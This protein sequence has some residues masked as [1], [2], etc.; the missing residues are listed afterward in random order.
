MQRVYHVS[1]KYFL[2]ILTVSGLLIQTAFY[3]IWTNKN[4][5]FISVNELIYQDFDSQVIE[6][7]SDHLRIYP[8][9]QC[10]CTKNVYIKLKQTNSDIYTVYL[11]R[12]LNAF[13]RN[14]NKSLQKMYLR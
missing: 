13:N 12:N 9:H 10:N 11:V 4:Q 3:I 6:V 1:K 8:P 7:N 2:L 5:P 14:E